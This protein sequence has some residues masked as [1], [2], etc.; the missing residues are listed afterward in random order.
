MGDKVY[1]DKFH[2]NHAT[3]ELD[4]RDLKEGSGLNH[5]PSGKFNANA[6]WCVIATL[7]HNM[8][9]W[10]NLIT[11]KAPNR[12]V[13]K[14]FRKKFIN[15]AGRVTKAARSF[16]LHLPTHWKYAKEW[17]STFESLRALQFKT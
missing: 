4:I 15:V 1:L 13:A 10:I 11:T 9:R 3:V 6:P 5:M 16:I 14:T 17:I 2:R 7:A 12:I 8:I